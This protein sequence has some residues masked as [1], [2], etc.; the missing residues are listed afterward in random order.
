MAD[1]QI[2]ELIKTMSDY[3]P[4][5]PFLKNKH[6]QRGA[7]QKPAKRIV[8]YSNVFK[9]EGTTSSSQAFQDDST[10]YRTSDIVDGKYEDQFDQDLEI[11]EF[12][13]EPSHQDNYYSRDTL[14]FNPEQD[15]Y[16]NYAYQDQQ[17]SSQPLARASTSKPI[18]KRGPRGQP[19]P[20]QQVNAAPRRQSTHQPS[21][22]QPHRPHRGPQ[23]V[24]AQPLPSS[25]QFGQDLMANPMAKVGLD[26]TKNYVSSAYDNINKNMDSWAAKCFQG[27]FKKYFEITNAYLVKKVFFVFLPFLDKVEELS[28]GSFL[29]K[30][31]K[32]SQ[33][34]ENSMGDEGSSSGQGSEP[35]MKVTDL[36]LYIPLM[37]FVSYILLTCMYLGIT[38]Q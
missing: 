1:P 2:G 37:G 25:L 24:Q 27:S 35:P 29:G 28:S 4:V 16:D 38:S 30:L 12:E 8:N 14:D 17:Y 20:A 33:S 3:K 6:N 26:L 5:N 31:F 11:P 9:P 19:D 22:P 7:G 34:S 18:F 36:D 32:Q 13:V 21:R 10:G 23:G 15:S